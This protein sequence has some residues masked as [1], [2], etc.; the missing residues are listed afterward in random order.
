MS[1]GGAF[2][3]ATV[4]GFAMLFEVGVVGAGDLGGGPEEG[5]GCGG[6]AGADRRGLAVEEGGVGEPG[7]REGAWCEGRSARDG[8]F[9]AG[10]DVQAAQGGDGLA[11]GFADGGGLAPAGCGRVGAGTPYPTSSPALPAR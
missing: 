8:V 3:D 9:A 2:P 11:D 10:G 6:P 1:T 7:R 4:G 5:G